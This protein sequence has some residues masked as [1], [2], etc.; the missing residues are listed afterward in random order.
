MFNVWVSAALTKAALPLTRHP[1][2]EVGICSDG[3]AGGDCWLVVQACSASAKT[4]HS[5]PLLVRV[6]L[7]FKFDA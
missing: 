5:Q 4:S 2:Q 6:G 7:A 3:A 1:V